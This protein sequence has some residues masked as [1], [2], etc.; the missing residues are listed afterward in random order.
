MKVKLM[1]EYDCSPIWIIKEDSIENPSI[2]ELVLSDD[3][4][5]KLLIWI[6]LFEGTLNESYPP[7]SG[8]KDMDSLNDFEDKAQEIVNDLKSELKVEI[9]YIKTSSLIT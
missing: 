2:N 3:V 9:I 8:F 7:D 4:K 5:E 6:E 1:A